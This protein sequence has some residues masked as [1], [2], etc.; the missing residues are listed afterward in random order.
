MATYLQL[1]QK[2]IRK[3]A[4]KVEAPTTVV[5]AT[6]LTFLFVEWVQD[7][8]KSIQLEHLGWSW[9]VA[10]DQSLDIDSATDEY[11]LPSTLEYFDF[12]T[13][14]VY[15]E[16]DDELQI[17]HVDY[18]HWRNHLDKLNVAPGAKPI[19][20]T[21][22]P[23][24]KVAFYPIPDQGYKV[25]YDGLTA[26]QVMDYEDTAGAGTSDA[27]T[28]TGIIDVYHDAI[29]WKAVQYYAAHFEDGAKLQEAQTMFKPYQKYFEERE[30]E[31]VKVDTTAMY[32]G[33][34]SYYGY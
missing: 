34:R 7:A 32:G 15:D 30:L 33:R 19:C 17:Y 25:R 3:A 28:P 18:H 26:V 27:L 4:A 24:N 1:V 11:S 23:D 14:S 12:R 20:F 29:V 31:D 13:V 16:V 6:A 22:T 5:G 9:R 21:V 10:R 8:W 2:A